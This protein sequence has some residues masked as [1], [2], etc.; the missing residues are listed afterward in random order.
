[1]QFQEGILCGDKREL[2]ALQ[3][4]IQGSHLEGIKLGDFEICAANQRNTWLSESLKLVDLDSIFNPLSYKEKTEDVDFVFGDSTF[5]QAKN[6]TRFVLL[7]ILNLSPDERVV[8]YKQAKGMNF[9]C[10]R[11]GHI[12]LQLF[13]ENG[14][15]KTFRTRKGAQKLDPLVDKVKTGRGVTKKKRFY[16][17]QRLNNGGEVKVSRQVQVYFSSKHPLFPFDVGDKQD[18]R[19]NHFQAEEYDTILRSNKQR[20]VETPQL[21][22]EPFTISQDKKIKDGFGG[23]F[24]DILDKES[25][26]KPM[27]N[28][29]DIQSSKDDQEDAL[30]VPIGPMTRARGKQ[31]KE[32]LT[33]L[34]RELLDK[35]NIQKSIG[36]D[37]HQVQ[38]LLNM[39]QAHKS[40]K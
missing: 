7:Q 21:A 31:I 11:K 40:P 12:E 9:L 36:Y 37:I 30:Q 1:M 28:D 23:L 34:I 15:A 39:I 3:D 17:L 2:C 14:V 29:E 8:N 24:Q 10:K 18:L 19:T 13:G 25:L 26:K 5:W 33:G 16:K 38:P 22:I 6:E 20:D 32:T 35:E 27:G 4:K